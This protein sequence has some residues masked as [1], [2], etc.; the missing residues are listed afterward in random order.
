[1]LNQ[2]MF[3]RLLATAAL[4]AIASSALAQVPK[5]YQAVYRELEGKLTAFEIRLPPRSSGTPSIRAAA[6]MGADC[7]RGEIMLEAGQREA[8]VREL[9]ALKLLGA[10]GIVLRVCYPL[11][12]PGFRD[13]QPFID[14]YANL[15]NE[16]RARGLRLLVEHNCLLP[17][18]SAIDP[19]VYYKKLTAPRFAR[20]RF[21]ELKTIVLALQPDY[22]TLV[23]EPRTYAAGLT[24]TVKD[25]KK[26]VDSS[27]RT[28]TRELGSFPTALG[29]GDGLWNDFDYVQAFAQIPGLAYIDLHAYPIAAGDEEFLRRLL[30]WPDRVRAIDPAK[31]IVMSELWLNKVGAAEKIKSAIDPLVLARDVYGF[32]SSLDQK[33][34]RIVSVA[35]REKQIELTAVFRS[36]YLFSY[37]D[38]NDPLTF[39]LKPAELLGLAAQRADEAIIHGKVTDTGLAFQGM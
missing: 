39:R 35:A 15:A 1:M 11:F 14:F 38:Y 13:P 18:Y 16:I 12:T 22:L 2:S 7:Q 27:V 30:D 33:F 31:R 20:E 4:L 21:Q 3:V 8:T 28:L 36:H 5:R 23:S 37:L 32:W 19:R 24:L 10:Q 9:E 26:Y 25:W 29:A 6:L 17:A 34:L